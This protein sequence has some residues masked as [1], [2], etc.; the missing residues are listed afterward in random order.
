[1]LQFGTLPITRRMLAR[2]LENLLFFVALPAL[3]Q[4]NNIALVHLS[5]DASN[6]VPGLMQK[7]PGSGLSS[8]QCLDQMKFDCV[9]E[10]RSICGK[11]IKALPDG[12][13][14]DSGYTNILQAPLNHSWLVPGSVIDRRANLVEGDQPACLCVGLVFLTDLPKKPVAKVFDYVDLTG[15]PTGQYTYTSLG[16]IQRTV[17]RFSAKLANAVQWKINPGKNQAQNH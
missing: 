3:A 1:M 13:I 15:Y 10:R 12:F 9:Q 8:G 4:N 17:R 16:D 11:I 2:A 6:S 7:Q 14:V 5:N